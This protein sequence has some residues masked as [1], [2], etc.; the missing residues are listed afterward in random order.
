[1]TAHC[2][3]GS[4]VHISYLQMVVTIVYC[5]FVICMRLR[6]SYSDPLA[7]FEPTYLFH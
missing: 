2:D 4:L 1:M 6:S 5:A 3:L 7:T